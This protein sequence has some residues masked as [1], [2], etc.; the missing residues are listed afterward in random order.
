M[1]QLLYTFEE[2]GKVADNKKL[3]GGKGSGL[4]EMSKIG[5]PVPPG[6]V[7][8]TVQCKEYYNTNG[9]KL[10]EALIKEINERGI[11]YV[12]E[13]T[14]KKFGD[15]SNPLLVSVR[16]GAAMSM[17]GMMD[18]ILNLGLNDETVK[19][20]AKMTNNNE[21]FA[22]D[23]YRRFISL[24]G[25]ITLGVP[26]ECYDS[27]LD[28]MKEDKK[29]KQDCDLDTAS[30]KTL[31]KQFKEITEKKTNKKFPENV[32]DQLK[33]AIESVFGSWMGKRAVDYR[34]EFKITEDQADGT[35][36]TIVSMIFGNV[37]SKSGTGVAFTR[38]PGTGENVFYGEYLLNAQGEDV[39]AGI[40]TPHEINQMKDELPECYKQLCDI[41]DKLEKHYHEVQDFEFTIQDGVL[42]M[43]Q[44]RNGKLN[45][46]ATIRTS[47]EM[48]ENKSNQLITKEEALLRIKPEMIDQLLH[49]Q[50]DEEEMKK[51][52][53]SKSVLNGLNASPGAA[54]GIVVFNAD[55]AVKI[56]NEKGKPDIIL[57][58]IE[59]KPE[60]IHGFFVSNGILTARGGKTS[61]AA[62]VARG[63]GKPCVS[64]CEHLKINYETKTAI[65]ES[66]D[67]NNDNKIIIKEGDL[68]TI[69]GTNGSVYIGKIPLIEPKIT[70]NFS[71]IL[72][73]CNELKRLKIYCNADTPTMVQKAIDYGCEGIGL[74]RTERMFNQSDR[75]PTVVSMIVSET[76]EE[77]CKYLDELL[78]LQKKDFMEIFKIINGLP[79]T[80]RLLDPP[81]HEF[82]PS[83]EELITDIYE[84]KIA[85]KE[86]S[87]EYNAKQKLFKKVRELK[88]INPMI[89]HRGIRLGIS[90]PEI[91]E[92][93]VRAIL[94]AKVECI[95]ANPN[96]KIH[97]EIMLPN[98]TDIN[99][100]KYI[101]K[102][103]F[104]PITEE[105][106][107]KYNITDIANKDNVDIIQYKIGTMIEC[108][109][110]ALSADEL[111]TECEFF[112]F[113][114]NDLTQG[115]FSYSREDVENKFMGK[116]LEEKI[117]KNNPFEVLDEKGVL[118]VMKMGIDGGRSSRPD[119]ET[120]ICG[121]HGGD[122]E[123][124][125]LCDKIG[126]T[127]V[128]CSSYRIPIARLCA[129]QSNIKHSKH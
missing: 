28:K 33:Y 72:E 76:K 37:N 18:T 30:L 95:K 13:K 49:P 68:I 96:L 60:D 46:T 89:G 80:I 50:I 32:Y 10:S 62:V 48:Y 7:I 34:K 79:I 47:V 5:L 45:A 1:S 113:G 107:K 110:A 55:D 124:I 128:S 88:E 64:G 123:S 8:P 25:K 126:L 53:I 4:C 85:K 58:R 35:A 31:C 65:I 2:G 120:G 15:A 63:M 84:L 59:T 111:A 56:Y 116:Y 71:K 100:V 26:D 83:E 66:E 105:L 69:D 57:V 81:L 42:Y 98:V 75:L 6:F 21:R 103:V 24:Y 19:G 27:I 114:T 43:L 12:E 115:T 44:T 29:V 97:L 92:M 52:N 127:Y 3:L 102:H 93:Q 14:G 86:G 61:H 9:R 73:W 11:K 121:E 67:S 54:S 117:L 51:N 70:G 17:P 39:V 23:S 16:S 129:A 119:I 118:K 74:V 38:D 87:D 20:L 101:K 125:E 122:P 41:R 78:K 108:V 109:R 104:V 99:E 91:Y 94:E 82:L 90:Y 36:V 40:R 22:Y 77:R 106:K 112:S